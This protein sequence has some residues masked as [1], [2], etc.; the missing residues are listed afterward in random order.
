M[1]YPSKT[2]PLP[3]NSFKMAILHQNDTGYFICHRKY[4]EE[5][6]G[7]PYKDIYFDIKTPFLKDLEA[8]SIARFKE[9]GLKKR[10]RRKK[11]VIERKLPIEESHINNYLTEIS[12]FFREPPSPEDF[13]QNNKPARKAVDTFL[14]STSVLQDTSSNLEYFNETNNEIV[15]KIHGQSCIIPPR[16]KFYR[17]DVSSLDILV[18]LK[19][20]FPL[21]I[22]DPP[23][24][25][26][27][28]KRKRKSSSNSYHSLENDVLKT[29][30]IE[31]LC[32]ENTLVAIWCTNSSIHLDY[33]R[34]I[35]LPTWNLTYVATWFWIKVDFF[36]CLH[37]V[38]CKYRTLPFAL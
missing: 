21:I 13:R 27:F 22:M 18:N 3:R 6:Y 12:S 5:I 9:T 26:R 38:Q 32:Q 10:K 31:K 24:I 28:I 36:F 29:M 14:L 1:K 11:F 16:S 7:R 37:L 30:P 17:H 4:S 15:I 34:N 19:Q 33:L 25:N 35:L 8:E 20:K 2:F 23:W